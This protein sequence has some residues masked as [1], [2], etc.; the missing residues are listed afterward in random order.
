MIGGFFQITIPVL[1][2]A[3]TLAISTDGTV[4]MYDLVFDSAGSLYGT[5][6]SGGSFNLGS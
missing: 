6:A 1:S 5:T 2:L 4:P 3:A